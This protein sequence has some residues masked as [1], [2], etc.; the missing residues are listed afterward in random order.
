MI[1]INLLPAEKRK[2]E[3]TPLPRLT[4]IMITAAAAA[5]ILVWIAWVF[6]EITKTSGEIDAATNELNSLKPRLPEFE[7]LTAKHAR[8]KAKITEINDLS[9]R[10]VEEGWWRAVNALWDVVNNSPRVWIDDLR[11]LDERAVQGEFKRADPDDKLAPPYGV[12]LRCHVAG[13]EVVEMTKFRNAL[14]AHP[15]LKEMLTYVNMNVDW[16]VDD[17]KEFDIK[18][19]ISFGITIVGPQNK[20]KKKGSPP[21]GGPAAPG[22]APVGAQPPAAPAG[23]AK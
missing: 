22:T 5:G 18:N 12:T 11:A 4:L 3:R 7:S 21:A 8:L 20:L 2:V 14:K 23:V 16:K 6:L 19:S 15:V 9:K 13:D 17:E 10:D 1:R